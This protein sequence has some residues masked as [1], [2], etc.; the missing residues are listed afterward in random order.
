MKYGPGN[1]KMSEGEIIKASKRGNN[2][3]IKSLIRHGTN[4]EITT[5]YG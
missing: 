2:N 1:M 4:T 3:V 5:D